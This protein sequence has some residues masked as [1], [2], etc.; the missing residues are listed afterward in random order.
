MEETKLEIG[1]LLKLYWNNS[2]KEVENRIFEYIPF[3]PSKQSK[4]LEA[5]DIVKRFKFLSIVRF[6]GF[7][8]TFILI[9][10]DATTAFDTFSFLSMY[11]E[12][13]LVKLSVL[14]FVLLFI[15]SLVFLVINIHRERTTDMLHDLEEKY[16]SELY[17]KNF[18]E[19]YELCENRANVLNTILANAAKENISEDKLQKYFE[20]MALKHLEIVKEKDKLRKE[21]EDAQ[22][23]EVKDKVTPKEKNKTA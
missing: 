17:K 4:E 2:T 10:I 14:Y 5:Q 1:G 6:I 3:L 19:L 20:D 18:P 11:G 7:I 8:L 12:L 21:K 23:K 16:V 13:S 9:V 22:H 15:S